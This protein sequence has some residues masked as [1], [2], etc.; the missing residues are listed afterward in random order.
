MLMIMVM[1]VAMIDDD[2]GGRFGED[3]Y[4]FRR[5]DDDCHH[6]HVDDGGDADEYQVVPAAPTT[7]S[8]DV[9]LWRAYCVS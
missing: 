6:Y 1:V 7:C 9:G 2:D 8:I 4:G 3:G 5:C